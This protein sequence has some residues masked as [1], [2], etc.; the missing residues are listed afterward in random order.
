MDKLNRF[1]QAQENTYKIALREIKNGKKE[2]HWM[3]YIFPQIKGLGFSEMSNFYG[4]TDIRE[5]REYLKHPILGKRLIEISGE[6]L[7][8]KH[9]DIDKVFYY[10]DNLKLHSCMTL[11]YE[12]AGPDSVFDFV[13]GKYFNG[14]LDK[15][16]LDIIKAE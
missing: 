12:V 14:E 9:D 1:L 6:L 4:I 8:I 7:K 5:A 16:T 11:F 13:L 10:P 2:S 3:W 15:L